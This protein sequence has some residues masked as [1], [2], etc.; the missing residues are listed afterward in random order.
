MAKPSEWRYVHTRCAL[1]DRCRSR[2][3]LTAGGWKAER[4]CIY[5]GPFSAQAELVAPGTVQADAEP[6]KAALPLPVIPDSVLTT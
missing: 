6:L 5:G 4:G 1:C 2:L 3:R